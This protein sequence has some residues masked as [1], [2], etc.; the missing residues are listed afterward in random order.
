MLTVKLRKNRMIVINVKAIEARIEE[1]DRLMNDTGVTA[2]QY[3]EWQ[4]LFK[5]LEELGLA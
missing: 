1:L 3:A 5:I 4:R 2:E